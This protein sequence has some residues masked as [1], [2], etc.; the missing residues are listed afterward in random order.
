M[1]TPNYMAPEQATDAK[2]V[3]GRADVYSFAATVYAA[4][5]GRPPFEAES[6]TAL[7]LQVTMQPAP[8]L[9][10]SR[11]D[12]PPALDDVLAACMEKDPA[13]RPPTIDA[14]WRAMRSALGGPVS[15]AQAAVAAASPAVAG[16]SQSFP[17]PAA[18][19]QTT[20]SGASGQTI[21]GARSRRL[22]L[23]LAAV[24]AVGLVVAI[25]VLAGGGTSSST[26]ATELGAVAAG[27]VVPV[28]ERVDRGELLDPTAD[29][30]VAPAVEPIDAVAAAPLDA[31][32]ALAPPADAPVVAPPVD[33]AA[34][35]K[36]VRTERRPEC[37]RSALERVIARASASQRTELKRRVES[38][39]SDGGLGRRDRDRLLASIQKLG[40]TTVA[41]GKGSGTA[42]PVTPP[43]PPPP[44]PDELVCTKPS[45]AAVYSSRAPS[46]DAARK[47]LQRLG[48]CESDHKISAG[49]A[50]TAR[51]AL[52]AIVLSQ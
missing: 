46:K 2:S 49:D 48:K 42:G 26:P 52:T 10:A 51:S 1:G 43:P 36:V 50:R 33:A 17:K 44:P 19:H 45:F 11:P 3:D 34:T 32:E 14:A 20:L 22:G 28:E 15:T 24:G 12:A 29:P 31:A 35:P 16:A 27:E 21:R 13:R 5:T 7:L 37:A 6:T 39:A 25:V 18:P 8:R 9:R 41:T 30:V 23:G 47:A 38:C 4:L 40:A